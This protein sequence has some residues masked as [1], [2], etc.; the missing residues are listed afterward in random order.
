MVSDN[1]QVL[2]LIDREELA[3]LALD[4]SNIDSPSGREKEVG[5]FIEAWLRREGFKTRVISLFP[6][7]PNVVGIFKGTGGGYSL[8]F[9]SHMD[10]TGPDVLGRRDPAKPIYHSAWREG[11]NLYGYGI[12]NDKGP[13]AC[14]L[15]AAKAIKDAGI[16]MKGDLLLTA[17]S[18][19]SEWEPVD[20]YQSPGW[21][22]HEAGA[23]FMV[24]HGAVADYAL[25]AEATNFHLAW[26][27][28][29]VVLFKISVFG[30]EAHYTPYI[31]GPYP[32]EKHPNAII[33]MSK[34]VEKIEDWGQRYEKEHTY[35]CP[36]GTLIPK[37]NVGAIRGGVPYN[38]ALT[39]EVCFAYV[40]VRM[41]PGQDVLAIKTELEELVTSL[42]IEGEVEI[43]SF[44]RGFEAQ[45]IERLAKAVEKAHDHVIGE[46]LQP[47]VGPEC[48]MWRDVN[49][50]NEMG[51]PAVTY[52]PTTG[53]GEGKYSLNL[54]A[55]VKAAQTY[56]LVS[57]DLCNQEK[58]GRT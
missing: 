16:A 15:L 38:P 55:L 26:L 5:E 33:R 4:L 44:R 50:F 39:S 32:P 2:A 12:I 40:D 29:G 23:R 9:N 46:K 11:D 42:S 18:G 30:D 22:G 45:N 3:N 34:L 36:G 43:F 41:A 57:L 17:V 47:V 25:V 21:L 52:G 20:E 37:V 6:H 1:D 31:K 51:I 56:A 35:V 10:V 27:E 8:L 7:R 28:A 58:K 13:M 24:T 54:D 48:S 14:F 49:V 53:A 19:E